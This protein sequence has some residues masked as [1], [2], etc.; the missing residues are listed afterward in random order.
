MFAKTRG[1]LQAPLTGLVPV[2]HAFTAVHT[3]FFED[4]GGRNK[5]GHGEFRVVSVSA[6]PAPGCGEMLNRTAL[7]FPR[8]LKPTD[9]D[10]WASTPWAVETK[11]W[12]RGSSPSKTTENC[13]APLAK[14]Q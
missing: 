2:I 7:R 4:V 10:P 12:I 3:A 14:F 11:T 1:Q 5:S 8:G 9:F 13:A 6:A